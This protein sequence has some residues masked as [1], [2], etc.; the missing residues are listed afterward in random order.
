M[1][2][3]DRSRL[4]PPTSPAVGYPVDELPPKAP[5]HAAERDTAVP[6]RRPVAAYGAVGGGDQHSEV[7]GPHRAIDL[8]WGSP[9]DIARAACTAWYLPVGS[10][11]PRRGSGPRDPAPWAASP[12]PA[13]TSPSPLAARA[14]GPTFRAP[15]LPRSVGAHAPVTGQGAAAP[16]QF[17]TFGC[18]AVTGQPAAGWASTAA[19]ARPFTLGVAEAEAACV[20]TVRGDPRAP[21]VLRG[22]IA[23]VEAGAPAAARVAVCPIETAKVSFFSRDKSYAG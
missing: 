22:A 13:H 12:R 10:E 5:L 17:L 2:S 23:G 4:G 18:P 20:V 8:S 16:A 3:F 7:P 1:P 21:H 15:L 14:S 19:H 6:F 11:V 9:L